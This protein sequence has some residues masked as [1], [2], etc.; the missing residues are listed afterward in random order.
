MRYLVKIAVVGLLLVSGNLK[1]QEFPYQYFNH[2][3]PLVSN[4]SLASFSSE[5]SI[6]V[7]SYNLWASGFKP[8]NDYMLSFSMS[9]DFKKRNRNRSYE[10]RVGFGAVLLNEKA[11]PFNLS[12]L[13][14]IYA[15]HIPV[16]GSNFLSLGICAMAENIMIDVNSLTPQQPNDPRLLTGNN[17]AFIIDG[18]FG[19]SLH[20]EN[21]LVSFSALNL[22]P[23]VFHFKNNS[24]EDVPVYRKFFISG[25]YNFKLAQN[26]N[27]QTNLTLR[28]SRLSN[29][30]LDFS[31][32]FDFTF[33]SFGLGYR[34]EKSVFVFTRIP[35]KDFIFS[36]TSENPFSSNHLIGSGHTFSL[37]WK[38]LH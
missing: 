3:N 8:L 12:V 2:L 29:V 31:G 35:Y 1:A 30:N 4:P 22:A 26:C 10:T 37:G 25:N 9:P 19:A 20:G 38:Y 32:T 21:Y 34:S 33:F 11:G 28:N 24:A 18:G 27:F 36:Y 16:D 23:G 13:Q 6:D 5:M 14:L 15:Y 17:N 7:G